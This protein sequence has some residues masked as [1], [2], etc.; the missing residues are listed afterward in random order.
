MCWYVSD[1]EDVYYLSI[2][3]LYPRFDIRDSNLYW[4]VVY[5]VLY[6]GHFGAAFNR[7]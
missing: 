2:M 1:R 6:Q 4:Y 7:I 5:L 3:L